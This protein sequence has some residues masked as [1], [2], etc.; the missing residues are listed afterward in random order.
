M[1]KIAE[2]SG[3]LIYPLGKF[4]FSIDL[5]GGRLIVGAQNSGVYMDGAIALYEASDNWGRADE[6]IF[7]GRSDLRFPRYASLCWN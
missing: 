3:R 4:G 5:V 1:K 2:R 6:V 7:P